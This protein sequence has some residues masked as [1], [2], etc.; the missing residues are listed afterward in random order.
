MPGSNETDTS[1]G[2]DEY[3]NNGYLKDQDM[4]TA[5]NQQMTYYDPTRTTGK[6]NQLPVSENYRNGSVTGYS[7]DYYN[8]LMVLRVRDKN[9]QGNHEDVV[10]W[11]ESRLHLQTAWL[12]ASSQM[13]GDD[14]Y[15]KS[16]AI[17][18]RMSK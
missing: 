16:Q 12:L 10:I 6:Y 17:P 5:N 9:W 15:L 1:N 4:R 3:G 14:D 2:N 7:R 8:K 13:I 11:T 18:V